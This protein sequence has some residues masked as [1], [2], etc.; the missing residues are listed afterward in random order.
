M[1]KARRIARAADIFVVIGTSLMVYPAANL[2]ESV[3]TDIPQFVI[4][5]SNSLVDMSELTWRGFIHI[6]TTAVEGIDILKEKLE[7]L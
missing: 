4:D 6:Q 1:I 7:A 3:L 5:P 2:I